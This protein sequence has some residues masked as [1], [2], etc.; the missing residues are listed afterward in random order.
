MRGRTVGF[1]IQS[2]DVARVLGDHL[3]IH[4]FTLL[5]GRAR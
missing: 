5:G 4:G 2:Q 3:V 1:M